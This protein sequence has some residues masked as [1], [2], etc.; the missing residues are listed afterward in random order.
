MSQGHMKLLLLGPSY[1]SNAN[2]V[3]TTSEN[4][5]PASGHRRARS[6][7]QS[8]CTR[9]SQQTSVALHDGPTKLVPTELVDAGEVTLVA[10][11]RHQESIKP[12]PSPV[13]PR[14]PSPESLTTAPAL[15]PSSS[16]A[17][18]SCCILRPE[19]AFGEPHLAGDQVLQKVYGA[20]LDGR[21]PAG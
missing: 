21:L 14:P 10:R 3:R 20:L 6:L 12:E 18:P 2:K 8:R 4:L 7:L 15:G 16:L 9:T 5:S 13:Q 17:V 1:L 11:Q 19:I